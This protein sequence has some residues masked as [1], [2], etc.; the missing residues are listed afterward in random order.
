MRRG[1]QNR[2]DCQGAF[3]QGVWQSSLKSWNNLFQ[4]LPTFAPCAGECFLSGSLLTR[5]ASP[6]FHEIFNMSTKILVLRAC[7][8][9]NEKSVK[10]SIGE[11][12]KNRESIFFSLKIRFNFGSIL[13]Q[14]LLLASMGRQS[15]LVFPTHWLS[16]FSLEFQIFFTKKSACVRSA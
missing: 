7:K 13:F 10:W 9:S 16:Q 8:K 15:S 12:F 3:A 11:F 14:L 1:I 5:P 6:N 4:F 2:E